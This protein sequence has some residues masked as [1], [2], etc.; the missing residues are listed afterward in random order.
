MQL[1]PEGTRIVANLAQRYGLSVDAVTTM[2]QAVMLG[3][4]NMAQFNHPEFGGSGQ[5]MRGGMTMVGD[6]FNHALKA[7]VDSLCDELAGLLASEPL[8][9]APAASQ[10]QNGPAV[11][12]FV[13][14]A[15]R[16]RGW[17]PTDL[18]APSSTGA[19]N[20]LRYAIFPAARCLAIDLNGQ[21]TLYDTLDHQISGVGQQQAGDA[22]FT[23]TSQ[24]GLVRVADLPVMTAIATAP[25]P[26]APPPLPGIGKPTADSGLQNVPAIEPSVESHTALP[27]AASD[28][29][30]IFAK[31]E[32]LAQLH[33]KGILTA[34][35]YAT[36]KVELLSRL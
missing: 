4:G 6:M 12:L 3:G 35:E 20:Q 24:H 7:R 15:D 32:G 18:G 14:G 34:E 1:T 5:W 29:S 33:Q 2:L 9:V 19:Q 23:F 26:A 16:S 25:E 21:L 28:D 17:W 13:G 11:S 22:S 8:W 31:I 10:R 30:A 27:A 36:K